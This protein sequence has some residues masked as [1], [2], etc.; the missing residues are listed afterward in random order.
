MFNSN[1]NFMETNLK[2]KS[3]TKSKTN[4]K[5]KA[6]VIMKL[7]TRATLKLN[8]QFKEHSKV[9]E[10]LNELNLGW[11]AYNYDQFSGLTLAEINK[12]SGRSNNRL[13]S[14]FKSRSSNFNFKEFSNESKHKK[15]SA[16]MRRMMKR[17]QNPPGYTNEINDEMNESQNIEELIS[18]S[19]NS[20]YDPDY[21]NLPKNFLKW[22]DY[23]GTAHNQVIIYIY[24]QIIY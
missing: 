16:K 18:S 11:K 7:K 5:S 23:V 9:V 17:R 10:R 14:E 21:K 1:I 15:L 2:S 6:K 3:K 4:L 13:P 8:S 22:R 19:S 24:L 20:E 12:F